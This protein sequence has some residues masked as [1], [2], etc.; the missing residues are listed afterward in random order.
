[1]KSGKKVRGFTLLEVLVAFTLLA[2][3]FGTIMKIITGAAKNTQKA[4]RNTKIALMAQSKMDELGLFEKVEEGTNSGDFDQWNSWQM[5]I[6][7]YDAPYDG[8][9]NQE[10]S[11]IELMEVTLTVFSHYGNKELSTEFKTLRAITPDYSKPRK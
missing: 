9:I 5:E 7:P 11:S 4:A 8:Q 6:V 10:F 1:M 3:S 2:L